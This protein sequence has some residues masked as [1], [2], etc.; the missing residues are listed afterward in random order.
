MTDEKLRKID[1]LAAADYGMM[2]SGMAGLLE[3]VRCT[4]ARVVVKSIMTAAYWEM[5]RG[6]V[7]HYRFSSRWVLKGRTYEKP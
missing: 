2:L 1:V 7:E 6:I 5:R 3:Q 4:T